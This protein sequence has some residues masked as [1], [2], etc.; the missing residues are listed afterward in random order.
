MKPKRTV[1][2]F[3]EEP[4]LSDLRLLL[5][6]HGYLVESCTDDAQRAAI[7][8]S[9]PIDLLLLGERVQNGAMRP[10]KGPTMEN[11]YEGD[12]VPVV[13]WSALLQ[14]KPDLLE[15][16]RVALIRKRGPRSVAGCQAASEGRSA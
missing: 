8:A 11:S 3:A 9:R 14:S 12:D 4:E 5:R 6:T 1:L 16:V 2:I 10:L 13:Q 7:M 15:R